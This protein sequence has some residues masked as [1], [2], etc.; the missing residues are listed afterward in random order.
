L[1]YCKRARDIEY[2]DGLTDDKDREWNN[3]MVEM[4]GGWWCWVW[5]DVEEGKRSRT[6]DSERA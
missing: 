3:G 5:S 6:D 2:D 1:P 4:G